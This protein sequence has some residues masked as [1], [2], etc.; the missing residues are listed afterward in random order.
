MD[1]VLKYQLDGSSLL[2]M[3]NSAASE[4]ERARKEQLEKSY[5]KYVAS[6][7]KKLKQKQL[8]MNFIN[9]RCS[10]ESFLN[11]AAQLDIELP[12]NDFSTICV[13]VEHRTDI[14]DIGFQNVFEEVAY[15]PIELDE[16]MIFLVHF[17]QKSGLFIIGKMNEIVNKLTKCLKSIKNII[18]YNTSS[19]CLEALPN[20]VLKLRNTSGIHFYNGMISFS[21]NQDSDFR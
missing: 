9:A 12:G 11:E 6:Q 21:F 19:C 7:E 8:W 14:K 15:Y 5:L 13:I 10:Q 4:A 16:E 20:E 18:T 17:N 3:L 1:Y 2:A